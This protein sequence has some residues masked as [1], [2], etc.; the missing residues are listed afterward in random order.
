M[1]GLKTYGFFH[2]IIFFLLAP[3]LASRSIIYS[4]G[5]NNDAFCTKIIKP[6]SFAIKGIG[7]LPIPLLFSLFFIILRVFKLLGGK[8]HGRVRGDLVDIKHSFSPF[9]SSNLIVAQKPIFRNVET[10]KKLIKSDI[11]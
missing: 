7:Y 5:S 9:R 4:F 11:L 6:D 8:I 1:L 3:F 10:D 2:F